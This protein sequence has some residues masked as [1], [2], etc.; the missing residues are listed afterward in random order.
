M[1]NIYNFTRKKLEEKLLSMNEKA[2]RATQIFE[3]IYRKNVKSIFGK[4]DIAFIGKKVAVFCRNHWQLL[5][6]ALN[7]HML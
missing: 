6:Y 5:K 3:W 4:P 7:Y 1:N 2:F